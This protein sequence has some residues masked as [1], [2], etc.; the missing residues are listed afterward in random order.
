[1]IYQKNE[2]NFKS[3]NVKKKGGSEQTFPYLDKFVPT[4]I[5]SWILLIP[6]K[7]PLVKILNIQI[8]F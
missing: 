1:M 3:L 5:A 7:Y 4:F 6:I 8:T 2:S